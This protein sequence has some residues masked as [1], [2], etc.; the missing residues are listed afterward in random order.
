MSAAGS[1]LPIALKQ[2][3]FGGMRPQRL[4]WPIHVKF[5]GH[6][7]VVAGRSMGLRFGSGSETREGESLNVRGWICAL[8]CAVE[9]DY[10]ESL[11]R[12]PGT[13]PLETFGICPLDLM[14]E[15]TCYRYRKHSLVS[16]C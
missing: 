7:H 14:A 1:F 16:W 12:Y 10:C 3:R 2:W 15:R 13:N 6:S 5:M 11:G 8:R 4:A 9:K